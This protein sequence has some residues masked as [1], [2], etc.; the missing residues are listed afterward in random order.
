MLPRPLK[1]WWLILTEAPILPISRPAPL[2][3]S[4]EEFK[5]FFRVTVPPIWDFCE[6]LFS[7]VKTKWPLVYC[8]AQVAW[9][10]LPDNTNV[11]GPVVNFPVPLY[12]V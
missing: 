1:P 8:K 4:N 2:L 6:Y 10:L 5:V 3:I 9:L 12:I 11:P 7:N